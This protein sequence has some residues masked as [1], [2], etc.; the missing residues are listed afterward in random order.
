MNEDN[1]VCK[2]IK[3]IKSNPNIGVMA[4]VALDP[5]TNH[6]HDGILKNEEILND[7]T[8]EAYPNKPCFKQMGCDVIAPSDMMDGRV[9]AIRK[10]LDKNNFKNV[11]FCHMLQKLRQFL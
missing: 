11:R 6:W 3:K 2:A 1:L 8:V 7:E 10:V 5:Y 9:G 4:D